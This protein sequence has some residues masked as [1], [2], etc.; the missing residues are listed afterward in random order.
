MAE[1]RVGVS[2]WR[3]ARWRGDFYPRDLV[4]RRELEYVAS[5]MNA[6]ELNGS[7]YSLLR[8]AMYQRMV[9]ETPEDFRVAVKG[10]RFI[11]HMKRLVDIESALANFFASGVLALGERLGPVLWQL[12]P[13]LPLD[14]E[15]LGGFLDLLPR[16][17]T[18]AAALARR[19][20][21]RL[22]G[23][24]VFTR[25]VRRARIRHALEVRHASFASAEAAALLREAGVALVVS[26]SPRRWPYLEEQTSDLMYARLHGHTDLYASGYSARSLDAWAAKARGWCDQ[27][28]D[29][30][31]YFDNDARGRAP[32][33]AMA[34][35]ERVRRPRRAA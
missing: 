3:Y 26:D 14:V 17:T 22:S 25:P 5:R 18:A 31:V 28:L 6:V 8:P 16:T 34:L 21:E 33:D 35:L 24:R 23:E 10:S 29:V 11:T 4:Q 13:D 12:P 1:I 27:G 30:H 7:F 15:R 19:H 20:D 32:Y 2:G 9:A